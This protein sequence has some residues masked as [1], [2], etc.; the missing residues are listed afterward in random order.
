MFAGGSWQTWT[1]DTL[2]KTITEQGSKR[3]DMPLGVSDYS[4]HV[5]W[6][7]KHVVGTISFASSYVDESNRFCHPVTK[8]EY[9]RYEYPRAREFA[10]VLDSWWDKNVQTYGDAEDALRPL[11]LKDLVL[12]AISGQLW[13]GGL[14][15]TWYPNRSR[16]IKELNVILDDGTVNSEVISQVGLSIAELEVF[17]REN[18]QTS[19]TKND[20]TR[21]FRTLGGYERFNTQVSKPEDGDDIV[22][23]LQDLAELKEKGLIDEEEFKSAKNKLLNKHTK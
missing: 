17:I 14:N 5:F 10:K 18:S 21:Y 9:A 7:V 3:P 15:S 1:L 6:G 12:L 2:A 19:I 16:L 22:T 13:A 4:E 23:K 20:L 11:S 8:I